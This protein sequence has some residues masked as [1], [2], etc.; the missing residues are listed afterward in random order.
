VVL[1]EPNAGYTLQQHKNDNMVPFPN[2][3]AGILI[4]IA[5]DN[6]LSWLIAPFGWGLCFCVYES[7]TWSDRRTAFIENAQSLGRTL[8]FG[9]SPR[10]AFYFV[11]YSTAVCTSLLFSAMSGLIKKLVS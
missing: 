4:G 8:K 6:W 10:M 11:E 3:I 2:V 1:L 9:M 7:F 5:N